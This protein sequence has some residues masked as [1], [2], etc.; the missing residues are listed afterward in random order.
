MCKAVVRVHAYPPRLRAVGEVSTQGASMLCVGGDL[1]PTSSHPA[2]IKHPAATSWQDPSYVTATVASQA[3]CASHALRHSA[4]SSN[5]KRQLQVTKL[6]VG[7]QTA[8]TQLCARSAPE[9]NT[10]ILNS[11]PWGCYCCCCCCWCSEAAIWQRCW[12]RCWCRRAHSRTRSM[13]PSITSPGAGRWGGSSLK[14]DNG[15]PWRPPPLPA[16]ANSRCSCSCC[17]W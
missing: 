6:L 5:T 15:M 4:R 14:F 16:V 17:C 3:S 8:Q 2:I 1:L 7:A 10:R 9:E 13:L 12:W 11:P